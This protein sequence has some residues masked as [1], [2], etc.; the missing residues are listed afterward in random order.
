MFYRGG[1]G[2]G[3]DDRRLTELQAENAALRSKLQEAVT[4]LNRLQTGP[5]HYAAVLKVQ[6][7]RVVLVYGGNF[8]EVP[9]PPF[10]IKAGQI[11]RVSL[12]QMGIIDVAGDAPCVGKLET[13]KAV[14]GEYIEID[15][16]GGVRICSPGL[17][18]GKLKPGDRV[19]LDGSGTLVVDT[20]GQEEKRFQFQGETGISW[21]DISGLE[22]AKRDL[23]EAIELPLQHP[24]VFRHY[25]RKP[26]KGILLYGPPGCGKTI[27]GKAA[28]T[29]I[30]RLHGGNGAR[31]CFLSVKGPELLDKFVGASEAAVRSLF[32]AAREHKAAHGYAAIIFLDECDA[33]LRRRGGGHNRIGGMEGTIVPQFLSE[34]DGLSGGDSSAIVI[35]ST[36][37]PDELDAAVVRDERIDRK[38]H[39]PRPDRVQAA[40]VLQLHLRGVPL[41][42]FDVD[43]AISSTVEDLFNDRPMWEVRFK[44]TIGDRTETFGLRDLLSGAMVKGLVTTAT[45]RALQRDLEK[46]GGKPTG[47]TETDLSYAVDAAYT[48]NLALDHRE[49]LDTWVHEQG[50]EVVSVKMARRK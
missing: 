31:T 16:G 21:D 26:V 22:D 17:H 29:S 6:A 25:G 18:A 34:M 32:Q 49:D 46:G 24:E 4:F 10:A 48:Q 35:L 47:I 37:R 1:G 3:S 40:A 12:D 2:G 43:T 42:G 33:I 28:A 19:T 23:R 11:A 9:R 30:Q 7:T 39:V 50:G 14:R 41:V 8:L 27:L 13:V 5:L 45:S 38:I 36:N 44:G 20:Y 15:A